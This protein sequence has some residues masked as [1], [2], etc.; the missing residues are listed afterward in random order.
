MTWARLPYTKI[1]MVQRKGQLFS[2]ATPTFP[3]LV[4]QGD[5]RKGRLPSLWAWDSSE[6][7]PLTRLLPGFSGTLPVPERLPLGGAR[8]GNSA[9]P[10]SYIHTTSL[11]AR[12]VNTR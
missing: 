1:Q 5:R 2:V 8:W 4:E 6:T 3:A 11:T 7:L 12:P 9:E 10:T